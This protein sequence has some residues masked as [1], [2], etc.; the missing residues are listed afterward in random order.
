MQTLQEN[1]DVKI[2]DEKR[3]NEPVPFMVL[4]EGSAMGKVVPKVW[5]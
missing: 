2:D 1:W 5:F 4:E 3:M